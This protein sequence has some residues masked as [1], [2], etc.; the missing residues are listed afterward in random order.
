[1][2]IKNT[3]QSLASKITVKGGIIAIA[4]TSLPLWGPWLKDAVTWHGRLQEER[5][6]M[7]SDYYRE[8][9]KLLIDPKRKSFEDVEQNEMNY[10]ARTLS[11][12][13]IGGLDGVWS[14]SLRPLA[15][16]HPRLT[17]LLPDNLSFVEDKRSKESILKFLYESKLIGYCHSEAEGKIVLDPG[18]I[19]RVDSEVDLQGANPQGANLGAISSNLCGINLAGTHLDR[20]EARDLNLTYADLSKSDLRSIDFSGSTLTNA[21]FSGADMQGLVVDGRTTLDGAIFQDAA[22]CYSSLHSLYD[23]SPDINGMSQAISKQLQ[24]SRLDRTTELP[25]MLSQSQKDHLYNTKSKSWK[26]SKQRSLRQG[27]RLPSHPCFSF[28]QRQ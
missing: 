25:A 14:L 19:K 27:G 20:A 13:A 9:A 24:A 11:L 8:M 16:L 5:S 12:N 23:G 15:R 22:L 4:I 6:K 17:A 1:M 28:S 7:L 3:I 18:Q 2:S 10:V 26:E 21:N